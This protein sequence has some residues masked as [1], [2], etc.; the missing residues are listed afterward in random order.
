MVSKKL[1]CNLSVLVPGA[2]Q[3]LV[4]L[5]A[6]RYP[7]LPVPITHLYLYHLSQCSLWI[8][9]ARNGWKQA[10]WRALML[11]FLVPR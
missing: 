7:E 5:F 1:W 3:C 11:L 8:R 2:G 10:P 9:L 6:P 4:L